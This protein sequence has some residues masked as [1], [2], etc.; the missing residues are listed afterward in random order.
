[1]SPSWYV[2]R[3]ATNG[4]M[5]WS[6][7]GWVDLSSARTFSSMEKRHPEWQLVPKNGEWVALP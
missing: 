4:R 2:I 1:M 3:D 7:N 6:D 5:F